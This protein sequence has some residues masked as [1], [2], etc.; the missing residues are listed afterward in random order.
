MNVSEFTITLDREEDLLDSIGLIC[1]NVDFI[2]EN[3]NAR[4]KRGN[5]DFKD[6]QFEDLNILRI[7]NRKIEILSNMYE[8]IERNNEVDEV[9]YKKEVWL[10]RKSVDN[11][12]KLLK[13]EED[14]LLDELLALNRRI[15]IK[16]K[17]KREREDD[18]INICEKNSGLNIEKKVLEMKLKE[19]SLEVYLT[20]IE[21]ETQS[22]C[23]QSLRSQLSS[24]AES[25]R[26]LSICSPLFQQ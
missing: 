19:L 16:N 1:K 4:W 11:L 10:R 22:Q 6:L 2:S 13:V 7:A 3:L 20:Q 26:F 18:Y 9:L 21:I 23:I 25:P 14:D 8:N 15:W 24:P 5:E 17:Q 12:I